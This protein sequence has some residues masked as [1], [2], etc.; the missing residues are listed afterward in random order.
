MA[1]EED[2]FDI[3]IYGDGGEEYQEEAQAQNAEMQ[4]HVPDASSTENG[5]HY[6]DNNAENMNGDVQ[7]TEAMDHSNAESE[8][9]VKQAPRVQPLKRKEG[10]DDRPVDPGATSALMISE[11]HWWIN[12]DDIRGWANQVNC[13]D[14]LQE[15]TFHEHKVNGKSKG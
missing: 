2:N 7:Q 4:D 9:P 5:F 14:E 6:T 11:L 15:I 10:M 12:D 8:Q 13:E 1:A 3:D